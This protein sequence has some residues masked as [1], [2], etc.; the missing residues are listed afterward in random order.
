MPD[1]VYFK[2]V[3]KVFEIQKHEFTNSYVDSLED[4][5]IDN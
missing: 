4:N 5:D 2:F 1:I 3:I